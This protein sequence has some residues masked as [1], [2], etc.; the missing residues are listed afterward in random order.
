[1]ISRFI[2]L[3]LLDFANEMATSSALGRK[4]GKFLNFYAPKMVVIE[5]WRIGIA[6][7]VLQLFFGEFMN[8]TRQ[9]RAGGLV[10]P[11]RPPPPPTSIP[12]ISSISSA[13]E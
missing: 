13:L 7:K 11:R 3:A 4:A 12:P 5:D 2:V 8:H 9:R 10:L 1:V 6:H